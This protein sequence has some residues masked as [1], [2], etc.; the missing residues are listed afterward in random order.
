M[1]KRS[2]SIMAS[3]WFALAHSARLSRDHMLKKI[4]LEHSIVTQGAAIVAPAW[5][6]LPV[7]EVDRCNPTTAMAMKSFGAEHRSQRLLQLIR[8]GR[9]PIRRLLE[10]VDPTIAS[11][12]GNDAAALD[13]H[14]ECEPSAPSRPVH[15]FFDACSRWLQQHESSSRNT[16]LGQP[17]GC[18]CEIT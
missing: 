14:V 8:G 3:S 12:R 13:P 16:V 15:G 11:P 7:P 6:L 9:Q 17:F 5:Q 1:E 10:C 18:E 2:R 4:H